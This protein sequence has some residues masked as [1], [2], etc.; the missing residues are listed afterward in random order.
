MLL[1]DRRR[2]AEHSRRFERA[3]V[4]LDLAGMPAIDRAA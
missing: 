3:S 4:T 2:V 1:L